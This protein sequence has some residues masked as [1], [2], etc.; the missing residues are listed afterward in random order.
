M[1]DL[2]PIVITREDVTRAKLPE[3]YKAALEAIKRCVEIDECQEWA[4]RHA[5]MASYARQIHT[6]SRQ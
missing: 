6:E 4:D 5:A 3:T 1:S 2:A